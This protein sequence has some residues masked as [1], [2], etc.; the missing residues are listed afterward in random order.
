M[1]WTG[2][3]QTEESACVCMTKIERKG[4]IPVPEVLMVP[5]VIKLQLAMHTAAFSRFRAPIPTAVLHG[6]AV[7]KKYKD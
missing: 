7:I 2:C 6:P 5:N 4:L 3:E 1:T